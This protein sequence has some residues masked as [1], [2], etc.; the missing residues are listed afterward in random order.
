MRL[1]TKFLGITLDDVADSEELKALTTGGQVIDGEQSFD[2]APRVINIPASPGANDFVTR[3]QVKE[4]AEQVMAR[5]ERMDWD[6]SGGVK[7]VI[8]KTP[9][10]LEPKPGPR[11]RIEYRGRYGWEVSY[12]WE[13]SDGPL[14]EGESAKGRQSY[15]APGGAYHC[16]QKEIRKIVWIR[17]PYVVCE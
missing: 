12:V 10:K 7:L 11:C 5:T 17:E 1:K 8:D 2:R 4:L 6:L 15:E 9:A 14:P 3:G 16:I 13:C